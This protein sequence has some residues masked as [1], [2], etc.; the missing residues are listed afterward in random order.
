MVTCVCSP[1]TLETRVSLSFSIGFRRSNLL[2]TE[3]FRLS[4]QLI[5]RSDVGYSTNSK[6]P[7]YNNLETY[8]LV[9]V[10]ARLQGERTFPG[11]SVSKGD[12]TT[13]ETTVG[14]AARR[15]PNATPRYVFVLRNSAPRGTKL[16]HQVAKLDF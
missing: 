13:Y 3:A 10:Y 2:D 11:G 8:A 12:G 15:I 9:F 5:T 14:G 7:K 4:V 16:R 6:L 1:W